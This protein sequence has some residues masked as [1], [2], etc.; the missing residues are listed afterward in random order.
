MSD[1]DPVARR[2][3]YL[4]TRELKGRQAAQKQE[5]KKK[6]PEAEKEKERVANKV[7]SDQNWAT[8]QVSREISEKNQKDVAQIRALA[9]TKR[10]EITQ[11]FKEVMA[12][13][14]SDAD[15]KEK[16]LIKER[17]AKL[18]KVAAKKKAKFAAVSEIP[19]NVSPEQYEK[20]RL[21]RIKIMNKIKGDA[22]REEGAI[23]AEYANKKTKA[24]NEARTRQ[25]F[26]RAVTNAQK[27]QIQTQLTSSLNNAKKRYETLKT[28]LGPK[29]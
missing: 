8:A 5:A 7:K 2:E 11:K 28:G 6:Q 9:K 17:D 10:E 29:R 27:E 21:R 20:L 22:A 13:L 15:R 14:S 16:E 19:D 25:N 26:A 3:Y 23:K 4:R 24:S 18:A 1:Y 12:K